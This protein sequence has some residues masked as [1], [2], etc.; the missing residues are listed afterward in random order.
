[1][2]AQ[3][4]LSILFV[5]FPALADSQSPTMLEPV[6]VSAARTET[7]A[8]GTTAGLTV[9]EREEI[10]QS[11]ASTLAD[12]LRARAGIHVA[13]LYG[14]GINATLDMRGF[15][16]TAGSNTLVLVD[17]RRLN[18]NSDIAPPALAGIDLDQIERIEIVRGS[19]GVLFGNQAVGGVVNV[20]TRRPTET[21][22]SVQVEGGSYD[23]KR[24]AAR[25][26]LAVPLGPGIELWGSRRSSDNYRDNNDSELENLGVRM[27][28][29]GDWGRIFAEAERTHTDQQLPGSLF[30]HE[31][32]EGLDQVGEE[33]E[34]ISR[35]WGLPGSLVD[36]YR[37]GGWPAVSGQLALIK[38]VENLPDAL[39]NDLVGA[40]RRASAADY[41]GDFS[42][43]E[44]DVFRVGL[45]SPTRAGWHLEAELTRRQEDRDFQIS[46]R[47]FPGSP[48]TQDRTT[49]TLNPR[50]VG[51]LTPWDQ[52]VDVTLG[53]DWEQ[54][55]YL[56]MT[57]FGPQSMD[58][59]IRGLYGQINATLGE[60]WSLSAGVRRAWV[61]N[62]IGRD[63][64]VT[65]Q[66]R[67]LQVNRRYDLDDRV[68]VGSFGISWS[69]APPWRLFARVDENFRFATVD[70]HT[71]PVSDQPVGLKNQTGISYE[72]GG[73]V[74][75]E[76]G[77]V[78]LSFYRLELDDEL[79][80]DAS[81]FFNINLERTR[82]EGVTLE[83]RWSPLDG[84]DLGGDY[85]Y[86]SAKITDGPF[87]GKDTPLVPEH[88]TRVWVDKALPWGLSAHAEALH[89]S[90]QVLGGDFNNSF[91]RLDPYTV[92]N[93]ALVC[94]R[95]PV[96]LGLKVNN[97][98]DERYSET[99]SVGYDAAFAQREAYFP[100]PERNFWVEAGYAF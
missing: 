80:F 6:V 90:S 29:A 50:L 8:S 94:R 53:G 48:A 89:V 75:W 51:H 91:S 34:R 81:T 92:V 55:E 12:L 68:T 20:I 43:S 40:D 78:E 37:A 95:G 99:G 52:R 30:G 49:D 67:S 3:S 83:T 1:M 17:G 32:D 62:R 60:R 44:A 22:A 19:A 64:T 25:A 27:E 77:R 18:N 96:S 28:Y 38:A 84:W 23:A 57:S 9:I 2:R 16:A 85:A 88:R 42:D 82:R 15:G 47:D 73:A 100:A 35:A 21:R 14:D 39:L 24:Y 79:S 11:G 71:N 98:L 7:P 33:L 13:D 97:L 10:E 45:R 31:M 86:T 70:E 58:Q 4:L 36:S 69:P 87:R 61:D 63:E 54:T 72:A 5:T 26:S 66:G 74:T 59:R 65:V 56:L 41:S 93:L 46:F 76:G